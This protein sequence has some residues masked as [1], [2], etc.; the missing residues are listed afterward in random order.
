MV[1][2]G[3]YNANDLHV[4]FKQEQAADITALSADATHIQEFTVSKA[5]WWQSAC[6]ID[7]LSL[8]VLVTHCPCK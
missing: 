3:R 6:V 8:S 1:E 7:A 5:K 4:N 2:S